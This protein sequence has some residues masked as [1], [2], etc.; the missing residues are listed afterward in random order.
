[1]AK[2]A[3][4]PDPDVGPL[5]PEGFRW[6]VATAGYRWEERFL[7]P[8]DVSRDSKSPWIDSPRAEVLVPNG[9]DPDDTRPWSPLRQH[10]L[11]RQF[12]NTRADRDGVLGFAN[13]FGQLTDGRPSTSVRPPW[14]FHLPAELL[15][16]WQKEVGA[17]RGVVRVFDALEAGRTKDLSQWVIR[18][19][20][21]DP[22]IQKAEVIRPKDDGTWL[23]L[24]TDEDGARFRFYLLGDPYVPIGAPD[25]L[26]RV[27]AAR[28]LV[29]SV[30]NQYLRNHCSPYLHPRQ[31]WADR[32]VLK[33]TPNDLVGAMW[34]QFARLLAGES[35]YRHCKVCNRLMELS[36]N[37]EGFRSDREICSAACKAKDHRRRVRE[38]K[39]L[40][41]E[42]KSVRE[43]AALF[44]QPTKVIKNWLAK[45][46]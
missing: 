3:P 19:R 30:T 2:T 41:A 25:R 28:L 9:R 12:V 27:A 33:M 42:G 39:Q 29:V 10:D 6:P 34:W 38:A 7:I 17:L 46:K 11:F 40:R 31:Y 14:R 8:T 21:L 20:E 24:F 22:R 13:R 37:G 4:R 5:G 18:W 15:G 35:A 26:D 23:L 45:T 44:E 16:D 36:T 1:M 43:I 32:Y